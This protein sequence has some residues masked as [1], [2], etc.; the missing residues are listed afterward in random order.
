VVLQILLGLLGYTTAFE[1]DRPLIGRPVLLLV[2]T[3]LYRLDTPPRRAG[4]LRPLRRPSRCS[5][6]LIFVEHPYLAARHAV[7]RS[8][9][10]DS[11]VPPDPECGVCTGG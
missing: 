3:E 8:V 6:S 1:V 5:R 9:S 2:G 7:L 4:V 10:R 11:R